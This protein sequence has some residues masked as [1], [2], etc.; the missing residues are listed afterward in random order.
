MVHGIQQKHAGAEAEQRRNKKAEKVGGGK[1]KREVGEQWAR[2]SERNRDKR[3]TSRS[4]RGNE[5]RP[6]RRQKGGKAPG[7][8]KNPAR[9]CM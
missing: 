5:K 4:W 8:E 2:L 7:W 6:A 1:A 3:V 9:R